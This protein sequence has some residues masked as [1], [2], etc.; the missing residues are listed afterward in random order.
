MATLTVQT[1]TTAGVVLTYNTAN[2]TTD[3]FVNNGRT[4]A[5][6]KNSSGANAYT[7]TATTQGTFKTFAITS[8]TAAV[9]V[10]SAGV[11]IGPFDT[12]V[13]NNSSG[14]CVLTYSGSAPATDL[15]VAVVSC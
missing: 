12:E 4:V 11:A 7:V 13:F 14:Q 1:P 3:N 10:S 6:I 8:P 15:T 2:A 9:A 5:I